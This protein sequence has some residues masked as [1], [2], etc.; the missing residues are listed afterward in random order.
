MIT[1]DFANQ[2]IG[3]IL[4]KS[5]ELNVA[6]HWGNETVLIGDIIKLIRDEENKGMLEL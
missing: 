6:W 1:E 5:S 3:R 4:D 2:L